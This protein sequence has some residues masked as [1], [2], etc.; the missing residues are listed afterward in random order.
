MDLLKVPFTSHF[1][2]YGS[3]FYKVSPGV[4]TLLNPEEKVLLKNPGLPDSAVPFFYFDLNLAELRDL[5][6]SDSILI[7]GTALEMAGFDYL[8]INSSHEVVVKLSEGPVV[9][10][11][12]SLKH[13]MECVYEYS[14]WLEEMEDKACF[15]GCLEI[16]REDVFD[17]FYTLRAIDTLAVK[18]GAFWNYIINTEMNIETI[19]VD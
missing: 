13:L 12:S 6:I 7:L 17:L 9:F 14:L 1:E 8:Y 5:H 10:V 15:E 18:E 11:N 19:L 16:G 2:N 3:R 4:S